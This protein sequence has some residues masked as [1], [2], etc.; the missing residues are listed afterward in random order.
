MPALLVPRFMH[1]GN[2]K[3]S[4]TSSCYRAKRILVISTPALMSP[5][6]NVCVYV[7][8]CVCVCVCVYAVFVCV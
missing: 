7:C 1:D 5:R 3:T 4:T 6:A 8:V 2:F